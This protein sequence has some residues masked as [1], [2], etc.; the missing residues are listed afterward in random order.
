MSALQSTVLLDKGILE[1]ANEAGNAACA[2]AVG[3]ATNE[4]VCHTIPVQV[5]IVCQNVI[6]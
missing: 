4:R 5:K 1:K 3:K 2:D 6:A